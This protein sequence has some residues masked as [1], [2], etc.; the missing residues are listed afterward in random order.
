MDCHCGTGEP[1]TGRASGVWLGHCE[2]WLTHS[3][4]TTVCFLKLAEGMLNG[5]R[6]DGRA[7]SYIDS[8][9]I[10]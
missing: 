1:L 7:D 4:R 9:S 3:N 5:A 6:G 10:Y 8:T 2:Q